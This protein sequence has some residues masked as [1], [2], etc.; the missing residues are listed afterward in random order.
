M[1]DID[2][3]DILYYFELLSYENKEQVV[4]GYIDEVM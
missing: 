1:D 2:K 3:M 4:M